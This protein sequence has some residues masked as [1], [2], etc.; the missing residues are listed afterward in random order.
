MSSL[1]GDYER[2]IHKSRYARWLDE[3]GRRENW[4]ET[5]A[6]LIDYYKEAANLTQE[7]RNTFF[8]AI[9][10]LECVPSMR[11]MMTAGPALDRC[12]VAGYN[13]AY[14]PVNNL[15]C[16][17]E[18]MYILMCGTGLGFSVEEKNVSHLPRISEGFDASDTTIVVHDSKEGWAKAFREL[19]SLL[20]AGQIPNWDVSRLRPVGARLKTFGGRS[21]GPD[22]LVR[23]FRFSVDLFTR[24]TGRKLTPLECHDLMC[25]V[26]EV[27]V[28]GGVRR[29][30]LISLSDLGSEAMA[31]AKS[32]DWWN[33]AVH[34]QLANN[35]A[36]FDQK[37]DIGEFLKEW[38]S[39][40][41]SKSGERGIFNRDAARRVVA[42]SGRRETEHDWGTNPCSEIIL[43]PFQFC[44]LTEVVVRSGDKFDDLKRKV[45][46][47]TILGTIQS[48][49]TNFRYLRKIW[50]RNCEDER[51][52]GVSFT[53]IA[54]NS[55]LFNG[56]IDLKKL[57]EHAVEVNK[58]WAERLGI[59]PSTAITCVKPSG[60]VS[61]LVDSASGLHPRWSR[62]YIRTVRNDIKDPISIFLKDAGV[63]CEID[64]RNPSVLVFS[65]PKKA[66]G[67]S[68][69]RSAITS[70]EFLE[71]WKMF[72]EKWCEHKP[73]I[74]ISVAEDEW[75]D[76]AAWVY[77]EFDLLSGVSFLPFDPTEYPQ[78][79]YQT[80]EEDYYN[81]L[82]EMMPEINWDDLVKYESED[83]TTSS[84]ELACTGGLCEI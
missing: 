11:A 3:K 46:L 44:N 15:R 54:D 22:P 38:K 81:H 61:Q 34:R 47:A 65:F 71:T 12:N 59:G 48:T 42:R 70:L 24:A 13:C 66:P 75:M 63:P 19:L 10:K 33:T 25:M 26:G 45:E 76:V 56:R 73:S 39:L 30:A 50:Q 84:Q 62:F 28:S 1:I 17:D 43:R 9:Y 78:A 60:T 52:L 7:E 80:I 68:I 82:V 41:D 32:G 6:R 53:G 64:Q 5:V 72:Q 49:F 55:D 23:L 18:A 20:V 21:S 58:I 2:F 14:M 37:P 69:V 16:F 83:M 74:T 77:R 4:D 29:S 67:A 27:V 31:K 35:S 40:Y 79:P 51:L 36:V 57:K 8:E